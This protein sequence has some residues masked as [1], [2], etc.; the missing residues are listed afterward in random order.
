[1]GAREGGHYTHA[2][3]AFV[4]RLVFVLELVVLVV[5]VVV[6]WLELCVCAL[7]S[8]ATTTTTTTKVARGTWLEPGRAGAFPFKS[9]CHAV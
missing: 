1:M 8:R 4:P 5:V 9:P 3:R 2:P 7:S 6:E